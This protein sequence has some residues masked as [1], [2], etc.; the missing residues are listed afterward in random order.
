MTLRRGM[1]TKVHSEMRRPGLPNTQFSA[2]PAS[3]TT[4]SNIKGLLASSKCLTLELRGEIIDVSSERL[5]RVYAAA[6]DPAL[7]EAAALRTH[8]VFKYIYRAF[9][10][11]GPTKALS[12]AN[13][14]SLY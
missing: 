3:R 2:S 10:D 7:I 9:A 14:L 5:N 11:H 12:K 4:G 6:A 8:E 1:P 13:L